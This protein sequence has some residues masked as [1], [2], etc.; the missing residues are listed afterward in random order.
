MGRWS[1]Q[2]HTVC[3][4]IKGMTAV[5]VVQIKKKSRSFEYITEYR[6]SDS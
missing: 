2:E 3:V 5:A 4:D 6:R 1:A